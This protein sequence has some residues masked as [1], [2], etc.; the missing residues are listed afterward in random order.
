[1]EYYS[2]TNTGHRLPE[3]VERTLQSRLADTL[4]P[5]KEY[6]VRSKNNL[7]LPSSWVASTVHKHNFQC[8]YL[9][10]LRS[11]IA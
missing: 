1:M 8:V 2:F 5:T 3:A 9:P 11:G 6:S 10:N 7:C 4:T